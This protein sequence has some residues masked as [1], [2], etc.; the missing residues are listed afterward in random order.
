MTKQDLKNYAEALLAFVNGK[1]IRVKPW[2]SVNW[3]LFVPKST[4]D[5]PRPD[6][7]YDFC[8]V[9]GS[10]TWVRLYRDSENRIRPWLSDSFSDFPQN[11]F[12]ITE[13]FKTFVSSNTHNDLPV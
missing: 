7:Y 13:P 8:V 1:K 11:Y 2:H 10:E 9:E 6:A 4:F 3:E 5:F 12:W